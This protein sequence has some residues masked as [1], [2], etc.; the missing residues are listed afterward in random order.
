MF[1]VICTGAAN[2]VEQPAILIGQKTGIELLLCLWLGGKFLF[3]KD[4]GNFFAEIYCQQSLPVLFTALKIYIQSFGGLLINKLWGGHHWR[5]IDMDNFQ[6]NSIL[7]F[8]QFVTSSKHTPANLFII[9][10]YQ[11]LWVC[12]QVNTDN[13][14]AVGWM[15]GQ[16]HHNRTVHMGL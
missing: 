11:G 10:A 8:G 6:W 1:K 9:E 3:G 2:I 14:I 5:F 16:G 12:R 7:A 13:A 4:I 15:F